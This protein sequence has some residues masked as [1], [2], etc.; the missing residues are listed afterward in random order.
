MRNEFGM[1]LTNKQTKKHFQNW[2]THSLCSTETFLLKCNNQVFVIT[3][4]VLDTAHQITEFIRAT[5][6]IFAHTNE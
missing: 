5:G 1:A 4:V 3:I 6:Q 2:S